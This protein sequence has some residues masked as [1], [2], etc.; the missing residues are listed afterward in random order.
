MSGTVSA[1]WQHWVFADRLAVVAKAPEETLG[2][3]LASFRVVAGNN[4]G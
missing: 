2:N 1:S 3:S 4:R